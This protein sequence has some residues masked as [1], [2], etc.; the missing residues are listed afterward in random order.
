MHDDPVGLANV[1]GLKAIALDA[2]GRTDDGREVARR[3][4]RLDRRC[5]RAL[6]GLA[7]SGPVLEPGHVMRVLQTRGR[8]I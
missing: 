6:V 7:C 5:K 3:A 4:L 2:L 1:L 8:G